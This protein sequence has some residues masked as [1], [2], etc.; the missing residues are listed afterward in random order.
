MK[1]PLDS[2]KIDA[3]LSCARPA[4]RLALVRAD[5]VRLKSRRM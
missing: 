3:S 5:P 4:G 2:Q 1:N